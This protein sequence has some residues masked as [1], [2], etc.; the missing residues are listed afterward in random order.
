[1]VPTGPTFNRICTEFESKM[2]GTA[3]I[4]EIYKVDNPL[5]VENYEKCKEEIEEKRGKDPE[6]V[7]V[8]HGTT[9]AAASNI[10]T[11]GFLTSYSKIAAFGKG[12]YASE[13]PIMALNY[14]KDTHKVGDYSFIFMCKFLKGTYGEGKS[15]QI[16]DTTMYDY[17]GG[18][19]K[20]HENIL[21]TPY[22]SGIVPLY[23][24]RYYK[25]GE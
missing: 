23:L 17:S 12:T 13:S 8:Y 25:Y 7:I 19:T 20:V 11:T 5:L 16:I 6:E 18:T 4:C 22:D 14:C 9:Y 1:M 10:V 3:C 24:I 21:V 2:K 15:G